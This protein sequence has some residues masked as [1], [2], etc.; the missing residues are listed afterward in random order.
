[1]ILEGIVTT[2]DGDGRVNIAPMGPQV[3]EAMQRFV[4]R[5]FQTSTTYQNL[6]RRGEGVLHVTDDVWLLA[7][8][9]IGPV[10][11]P[12]AMLPAERVEGMTLAGT[13]RWFE[14]RV[15]RLDDREERTT[16]DCGVVHCGRLRDFFGFNRAK[17][18]VVEAAILA[19][20]TDFLP[21]NE[22]LADFAKLSVLVQKTGGPT[23]HCAF[24]LLLDHVNRA[25]EQKGFAPLSI[26]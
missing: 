4:L 6:K 7:Q 17:H 22:I 18:A 16:I 11:P 8:A 24:R 5:P 12:P 14:F 15:T 3:D 25:A 23:E 20:R 2:L 13:C 10:E 9:A 1:M 21:I 19:T 26:A